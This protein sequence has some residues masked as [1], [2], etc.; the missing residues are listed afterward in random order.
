MIISNVHH[1]RDPFEYNN[2]KVGIH[3]LW[4]DVGRIDSSKGMD[5]WKLPWIDN[6]GGHGQDHPRP[7][8]TTLLHLPRSIETSDSSCISLSVTGQII[9]NHHL[10]FWSMVNFVLLFIIRRCIQR[11]VSTLAWPMS[12]KTH[13]P[14]NNTNWTLSKEE[15]YLIFLGTI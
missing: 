9:N 1:Q 7:Y 14:C 11:F 13:I 5:Y 15:D 2:G 6:P 3:L 10:N 8:A 12:V 4:P